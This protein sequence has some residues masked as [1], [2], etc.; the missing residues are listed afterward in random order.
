MKRI[1]L[2]SEVA[3]L[4]PAYSIDELRCC[5]GDI[6]AAALATVAGFCPAADQ[7]AESLDITMLSVASCAEEPAGTFSVEAPHR[8]RISAEQPLDQGASLALLLH[9]SGTTA[10]PKLIGL[11]HE[12]LCASAQSIAGLL[13]LTPE[14]RTLNVMPLFHVHGLVGCL[15]STLSAGASVYCSPGFNALHF[16]RWI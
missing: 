14:D 2:K 11:T 10:R 5:L 12:N 9:N 7:A 16:G 15:L 13:A 8:R 3:P 6:G 1:Q 4:N